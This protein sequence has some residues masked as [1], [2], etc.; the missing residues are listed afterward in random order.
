MNFE[1]K[2]GYEFKNKDL[3]ILALTH[4][5]YAHENG[6]KEYDERSQDG[7]KYRYKSAKTNACN[8]VRKTYHVSAN[9]KSDQT[10]SNHYKNKVFLFARVTRFVDSQ[11]VGK[12]QF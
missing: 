1:E 4:S 10:K 11:K 6:K 7:Q 3:M 5:S 8:Q 9:K 2:I 12:F